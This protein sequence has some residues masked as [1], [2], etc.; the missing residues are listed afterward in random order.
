M[1]GA[2]ADE[3]L[4]R[5][6]GARGRANA[7]QAIVAAVVAAGWAGAFLV[8]FDGQV[9]DERVG[10]LWATLP[11]VLLLRGAESAGEPAPAGPWRTV[12]GIAATAGGLGVILVEGLYDTGRLLGVP[13]PALLLLV[14]GLAL[15][16]IFERRERGPEPAGR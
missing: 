16:G 5:P 11:L 14:L 8:R 4:V 3:D 7:R 9:P 10:Q 2:Q 6:R 15:L 12:V 1:R 13:V